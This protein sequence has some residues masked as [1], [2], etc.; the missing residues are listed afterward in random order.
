M[1]EPRKLSME[2]A[3]QQEEAP[4]PVCTAPSHL[5]LTQQ[6]TLSF[7]Q[8]QLKEALH[9]PQALRAGERA[10]IWRGSASSLLYVTASHFSAAF[11]PSTW[12]Q[13][14]S[15]ALPTLLTSRTCHS[16][17]Q[18]VEGWVPSY[19]HGSRV[20]SSLKGPLEHSCRVHCKV[21]A[22]HN[23]LSA[24]GMPLWHNASAFTLKGLL[25]IPVWYDLWLWLLGWTLR[26]S[27]WDKTL[28]LH[29]H[30]SHIKRHGLL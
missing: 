3:L 1:A 18:P 23:A 7:C 10:L 17:S 27:K 8:Q 14:L 22:C 12:A 29:V 5:P 30:H 13:V 4:V 21:Q 15:S 2:G 25:V 24:L 6:G 11:Q 19:I 26:C 20:W 16:D 9:C 28:L